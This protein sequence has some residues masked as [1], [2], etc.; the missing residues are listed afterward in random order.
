MMLKENYFEKLKDFGARL[1]GSL[2]LDFDKS[3]EALDKVKKT[4]IF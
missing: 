1:H 3:C 2:G 4:P